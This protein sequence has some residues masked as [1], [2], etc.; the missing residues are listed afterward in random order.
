MEQA[1]LVGERVPS[2]ERKTF[3]DEVTKDDVYDST[4]RSGERG[5]APGPFRISTRG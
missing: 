2:S 1:R 5:A 3:V 4:R